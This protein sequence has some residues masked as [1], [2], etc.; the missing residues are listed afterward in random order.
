MKNHLEQPSA[1]RRPRLASGIALWAVL[2]S[3]AAGANP[4]DCPPAQRVA[5]GIYLLAG[6]AGEPSPANGGKVANRVFLDGVDGVVVIDPG[7]SAAAGL[8]LA[9][10]VARHTARPIRALI[11]TH[12]HPENVLANAAFPG[13]PIVA[14]AKA[15]QA[16]RSRCA[17][18]RKKLLERIGRPADGDEDAASLAMLTPNRLVDTRQT[19]TLAGR[20]LTLIPLGEAHSPGDLAILDDASGVLIG[21]DLTNTES[22]P[23]LH[24][25]NTEAALTALNLLSRMPEIRQVIPGRGPPF[26][27]A[28][29]AT[30]A[31]YLRTLWHYARSRVES[32]DGFVPPAAVPTELLPYSA[33]RDRQLLNIQHALR[34]AEAHWWAQEH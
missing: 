15:A 28:L 3:G 5:S 12:P 30:Q 9:C 33:E 34:E 17:D 13:L 24:D 23:D 4:A 32:P 6:A 16:M 10:S 27:P 1:V 8:D 2:A 31:D 25:G 22:L 29:L 21:G 26:D 20:R 7:P 11:N 14:S 19:L 18:C